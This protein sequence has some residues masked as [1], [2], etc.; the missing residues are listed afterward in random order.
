MLD[1][2]LHPALRRLLEKGK[3][4]EVLQILAAAKGNPYYAALAQRLLDTGL[5]AKTRLVDVNTMETLSNDPAVKESINEQLNTL[6]QI[7]TE[8]YPVEEQATIIA[9]LR[10][11]NLREVVTALGRMQSTLKQNKALPGQIEAFENTLGLFNRQYAWDGKYDPASDSI[12]L[13]SGAGKLT[14]HLFLHEALHA[15]TSHLLDNADKLTGIQRQGYDRLVELYEY[16]KKTL[17]LDEFAGEKIYGI[18]DLH[19][20]VSEALTNPEFQA[21]LRNLRYKAAPYSLWNSFTESI[22]KLFNVKKGYESNVMVETM[23]ATDAMIAGPMSLEGLVGSSGPK[24]M[25]GKVTRIKPM[26]PGMPNQPS[27]IKRLMTSRKWDNAL[28]REFRSLASSAR[29]YVLGVLTLRQLDDLVAGRL[30]QLT[31]FIRVTEEFLSRKNSIVQEVG[32]I[33]KSWEA[34]QSADPEMSQQLGRVMH[35]ATI[36]E[37]DPDRATT[38]QR[39]ANQDLMTEWGKLN[40]R[41]KKVYREVR[42]FYERRYSNYKRLMNRRI[43]QMRQLNVS[44]ATITEIRNEFEKGKLSGP[45]FPLMRFGRFWY[46]IGKGTSREYYM[47]ESEAARD[48]HIEERLQ[49]DPHLADTIGSNIGN[50]YAKQMDYHARESAFLKAVFEA[51][52]NIDVTGLSPADADAKKQELKDSYYQTYLSNQPDRSM[53]NQFIHRNNVAGYSEDALRSFATSSFNMAY[54]MARFEYSPEMFSQLDAARLQLKDRYNPNVGY[55]PAV[56]RETD[57]LRDYVNEVSKR[58]DNMLNPTDIGTIPSMLSNVGFIFYLSSIASAI[59]NVL[60]GVVIGF[61]T[62]VSQQVKANPTMGYTA[63]TGKVLYE[64]SRAAAQI[65]MTG[66]NVEVGERKIDSRL[67]SPSFD[68]SDNLSPVE[69]AAY[70]RFVADG[71]IDITATYDLSG[72]ASTPTEDYSGLRNKGMQ[73]LSYAFHHAERFNREVMAMSAFRAAM[74]KRASMP[75]RQQAF[76][77]SIAEAKNVTNTAMFDYSSANKPRYFQSPIARIVWQFKQFPQQ[78]TFFLTRSF[79]NSVKS[80]SEDQMIGMNPKE[81]AKFLADHADM[82]REA[83][84]RFVGTMGMSAIFSGVTGLWGFS[85]VAFIINAMFNVA[86]EDDE[87]PFDFELAFVNWANETF[88]ANMGTALTR[89]SFNALTGLDIGSRVKL[90]EMWFRDGRKNQDEAEALQ[91]FLVDLLGPTIGIGVNAARAVDLWNQGH[92]DRAVEAISPAFIKNAMIA[93][94]MSREG[95]ATTLRGDMLTENPSPFILMMQGLGLRS[96]ELA[97]RQYYNITVKGQEQKILKQRQNLLNYYGLTFMSNDVEANEEAFDKIMEFNDK[98]PS[99]RIP[100]DSIT[101]SIIERMKK[102]AQTENGLYIDKRLRESLSRQ[103]YLANQ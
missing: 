72:L 87:E 57:E 88:G 90:D 83:R 60:G 52:D 26:R 1:G 51:V 5:T 44:E 36:K 94:R 97:E 14:N 103:N 76:A 75:N 54:Q 4:N 13:R 46:Q 73:V 27:A 96:Q 64:T 48:R 62:L 89:G 86:G 23:F 84:A 58:M 40:P 8:L 34:L 16:A 47:F 24:A 31:N 33:S 7:V 98:H 25:A 42:N 50:D 74:D 55:N 56:V 43:I 2:Q 20:F 91:T 9:G 45:Y 68:R 59:T 3:T 11:T 10:S 17:S 77:E 39:N 41:A 22:R 99:V 100:A 71:L 38:D 6:S 93:Q 102:S 95:G 67:L 78:M 53:R 101:G 18:Q 30:P 32:D 70:N 69:R 28:M 49:K 82:K 19:E 65:M 21:Q 80:P 85:T 79:L 66:F 92:G 12:V 61:P 37:V 35:M 29:P 15:A 81:R 63:A